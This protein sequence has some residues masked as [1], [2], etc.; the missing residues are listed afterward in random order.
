M[1]VKI[2]Y[3]GQV[4][5]IVD[6]PE[7]VL[8]NYLVAGILPPFHEVVAEKAPSIKLYIPEIG[9]EIK[10]TADWTFDLYNESRNTTLMEK[11]G[12]TRDTEYAYRDPY[13]TIPCTIPAGAVLKVDRIYIRKGLS[14]F[15]SLSFLWVGERT[16]ARI[17]E[18]EAVS[19]NG[20]GAAPSRHPYTQKIPARPVR[21]WAKLSDVNNIEFEKA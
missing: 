13:T 3:P 1:K 11:I 18:R 5:S 10:L 14:D 7:H 8:K 16:K 2:S 17:V 21:F 6:A 12:D 19:Y 15:S 9:D 20:G 4:E